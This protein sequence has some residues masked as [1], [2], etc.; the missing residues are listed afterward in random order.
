MTEDAPAM[1]IDTP[2]TAMSFEFNRANGVV[3]SSKYVVFPEKLLSRLDG[4]Q[5]SPKET[6]QVG[7]GR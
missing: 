5:R 7:P 2:M 3:G 1:L 6:K 4:M